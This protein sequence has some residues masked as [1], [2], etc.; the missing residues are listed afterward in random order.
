MNIVFEYFVGEKLEKMAAV[1]RVKRRHDDEPLH[2]LLIACK[3]M[4]TSENEE[5]EET[6]T[7]G[8]LTTVL[9]FAGT[10]KNQVTFKSNSLMFLKIIYKTI[11]ILYISTSYNRKVMLLNT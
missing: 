5:V 9:K 1:L 11:Y 7:T 6:T 8:P 2:A 3:R 10:V 4:K